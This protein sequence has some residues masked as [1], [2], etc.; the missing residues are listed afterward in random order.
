MKGEVMRI[1]R[2]W[3]LATLMILSAIIAVPLALYARRPKPVEYPERALWQ[4]L[5]ERRA[6]KS[7]P[8]APKALKTADQGRSAAAETLELSR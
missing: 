3:T 7:R 5:S 6:K 2:R 1:R 8:A 4:A